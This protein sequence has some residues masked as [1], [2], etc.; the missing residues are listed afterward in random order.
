MFQTPQQLL[1]FSCNLRRGLGGAKAA[2]LG[3]GR[4]ACSRTDKWIGNSE[5]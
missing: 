1:F 4:E 3:P 2:W 5:Q